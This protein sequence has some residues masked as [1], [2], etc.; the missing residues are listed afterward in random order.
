MDV[1]DIH[2]RFPMIAPVLHSDEVLLLL[3]AACRDAGGQTRWARQHGL[4]HP[5][6]GDVLHGRRGL[7]DSILRALGLQ[8]AHPTYVT[9]QP[10]EIALYVADGVTLV[11][12][13]AD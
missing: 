7:G 5:Y 12:A 10:K 6:V 9:R 1:H 4:S 8:K 2:C 13:W 11:T 3:K